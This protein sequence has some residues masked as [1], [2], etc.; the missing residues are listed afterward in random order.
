MVKSQAIQLFVRLLRMHLLDLGP[1][2]GGL[3]AFDLK[4][5]IA[6]M[7]AR[8]AHPL[9]LEELAKEIGLSERHFFRAFKQSTGKTPHSYL[10]MQRVERAANLLRNSEMSATDIAF[11][12]GFSS[13]SHLTRIFKKAFGTGPLDYRRNWRQ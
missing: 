10:V 3:S 4:R 11:E 6:M 7:E 1:V 2:R 8:L 13:S 12:S 9:G 5:V